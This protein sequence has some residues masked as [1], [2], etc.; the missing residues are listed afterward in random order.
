MAITGT[1]RAH[2][3]ERFVVKELVVDGTTYAAASQDEAEAGSDNSKHMTPL[4]VKQALDAHAVQYSAAQS[5]DSAEKS[6]ARENIGAEATLPHTA[7]TFIRRNSANDDFEARTPQQVIDQLV[8]L[9][10]TA[11]DSNAAAVSVRSILERV[12]TP[13][14]FGAV[15]NGVADDT[16]ALQR[17]FTASGLLRKPL[18]DDPGNGIVYKTTSAI[19]I[20]DY[21]DVVFERAQ[22]HYAATTGWA[23]NANGSNWKFQPRGGLYSDALRTITGIS[24]ANPAVVTCPSHGFTTGMR[25]RITDVAGMTEVNLMNFTI[26]VI[27]ANSFSLDGIDSTSYT[28]YTSG[29]SALTYRSNHIGIYGIR[30]TISPFNQVWIENFD[31]SGARIWGFSDSAI[32]M[33]WCRDFRFDDLYMSDC[34][35]AGMLMHSGVRGKS[36]GRIEVHDIGPGSG[37][38]TGGYGVAFSRY[39]SDDLDYTQA[40]RSQLIH[41]DEVFA[42]NIPYYGIGLD[43]HG[44]YRISV[45]HLRTD[46]CHIACNLEA[47]PEDGDA[48]T[49]YITIG[50]FEC[51]GCDPT[52][53]DIGPAFAIDAVYWGTGGGDEI[54]RGIS[55]GSGSIK[56]HGHN[57]TFGTATF[58]DGAAIYITHVRGLTIGDV[59][60]IDCYKR[61][62]RT[63]E[64]CDGIAFSNM[65]C[66]DLVE[67]DSTREMFQFGAETLGTV[68]NIV[69]VGTGG[70]VFDVQAATAAGYGVRVGKTISYSSGIT[71]FTTAAEANLL[72]DPELASGTWTPTATVVAN[73]DGTPTFTGCQ[74]VR[75]GNRVTCWGTYTVDPTATGDVQV[76]CSLPIASNFTAT[77]DASGNFNFGTSGYAAAGTGGIFADATNDR[78]T[79]RHNAAT[80]ISGS[81]F[82]TFG[83]VIK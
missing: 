28:T 24:K 69:M 12:L 19:N 25:V 35:W 26:T 36:S 16:T 49:D 10:F 22:I 66:V 67:V 52:K 29:G 46:Y 60:F 54:T 78:V 14:M 38:V 74:Y 1:H 32:E 58:T 18:R 13:K 23:F 17:A 42:Y 51:I 8:D 75:V 81:A 53:H 65:T 59:R 44:G 40:P 72:Y 47:S 6:Q 73:A 68:D 63:V 4:R 56:W 3:R 79:F 33:Y 7:S 31:I 71:K 70:Y 57:N 64:N 30:S 55:I 62:V 80:T 48:A 37:S 34:G 20:P 76:G 50:S 21:A 11:S 83:Y 39:V 45:D 61:A 77:I 41:M 82:F 43:S 27:D 2:K 9:N 5:L 15:G